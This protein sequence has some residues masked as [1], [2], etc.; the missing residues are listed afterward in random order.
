M[1]SYGEY[2]KHHAILC[3][4]QAKLG[5]DSY[6]PY[7]ITIDAW[8]ATPSWKCRK[9]MKGLDV[10]IAMH[11][12]ESKLDTSRLHTTDIPEGSETSAW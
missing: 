10:Q 7:K 1:V 6:P 11:R 5:G 12:S 4:L 3:N 8:I 9:V 2:L